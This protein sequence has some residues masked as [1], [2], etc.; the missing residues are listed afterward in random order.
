MEERS[1]PCLI[2]KVLGGV[3]LSVK[4]SSRSE[5]DHREAPV[6]FSQRQHNNYAYMVFTFSVTD[7]FSEQTRLVCEEIILWPFFLSGSYTSPQLKIAINII[8]NGVRTYH[9]TL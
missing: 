5:S 8:T 4:I 2:I 9:A 7:I 6:W 1:L 3:I